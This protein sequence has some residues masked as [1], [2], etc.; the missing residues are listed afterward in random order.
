MR[1]GIEQLE[2]RKLLAGDAYEPNDNYQLATVL[3]S[4]DQTLQQLS[5]DTPTDN[6]WFL[7]TPR[8]SGRAN[9]AISFSHSR[10]NLDL[11]VDDQPSVRGVLASSSSST[12]EE[13]ISVD[14]SADRPI[15]IR[16]Y[17]AGGAVNPQYALSVGLENDPP[18]ISPIDDSVIDVDSTAGPIGFT[19]TDTDTPSFNLVLS[20][21]ASNMRLVPRGSI[22]ISGTDDRRTISITPARGEI[23]SSTI[24]LSAMDRDGARTEVQFQL[25]VNARSD[26]DG[27]GLV[28]DWETEGIDWNN[29]GI[30]D[31]DLPGMGAD[32][33]RKDLFVEVDA[34]AGRGPLPRTNS[35]QDVVAAGLATGTVLDDVVQAFLRAPVRNPD[36]STGI[37]L[38]LQVDELD[39]PIPAFAF[40]EWE[41][42]TA[43]KCGTDL[44]CDPSQEKGQQAD[45]R[46]GRADER[47][48]DNWRNVLSAKRLAFRYALFGDRWGE[49]SASG[50]AELPGNDLLV[51]L[52]GWPNPQT[53]SPHGGTG[54]D[55][56]GTFMHMLGHNL[57]LRNGGGDE[58]NYKP[59]YFSVMNFHWQVPSS[60]LG[61]H[62][63]YSREKLPS[64]DENALN[65]ARGVGFPVGSIHD[66][67]RHRVHAGSVD[68]GRVALVGPVDWDGDGSSNESSVAIDVNFDGK[69]GLLEGH[70][71]W[72]NLKLGFGG[73]SS[74]PDLPIPGGGLPQFP[75]EVFP[76]DNRNKYDIPP[77]AYEVNDSAATASPLRSADFDDELTLH[78][79][80]DVDWLRWVSQ[81]AG[82]VAVELVSAQDQ[83][84]D[85]GLQLFNKTAQELFPLGWSQSLTTHEFR[86]QSEPLSLFIHAPGTGYYQLNIDGP[87]VWH[88]AGDGH[89]W[90]DP[91]NWNVDGAAGMPTPPDHLSFLPHNSNAPVTIDL[92]GT[93]SAASLTFLDDYTLNGNQ[94]LL[95]SG[96]VFVSAGSTV[97]INADMP[98]TFVL[99]K[100]GDGTLIVNGN[101]SANVFVL[102]GTLAMS[103]TANGLHVQ[104]G[105]TLIP[106]TAAGNLAVS[107]PSTID[108]ALAI[109]IG[110]Q[111]TSQLV[112]TANLQLTP[113]SQLEV[114]SAEPL[115]GLG[116]AIRPVAEAGQLTGVFA[117]VPNP[118]HLRRGLFLREV[119]T[120]YAT[121]RVD[122]KFFQA[123][124]GDSNGDGMIDQV[125]LI[126]ALQGNRYLQGPAATWEQGDWDGDNDFDQFDLVEALATGLYLKGTYAT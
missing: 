3:P 56:A 126:L 12:D 4:S 8:R 71:D 1:L 16:V 88:G 54:R 118:G 11:A 10:G 66:V 62:L 87:E 27:D 57:G 36:G 68:T 80:I 124:P 23:G 98:Q 117:Q 77:D 9:I 99:L 28:D 76:L 107:G 59:N 85:L 14:V 119:L 30:V 111:S 73:L 106:R 100:T 96:S 15:Y 40:T 115:S 121:D 39:I 20:A 24:V 34:M 97:T 48:G 108:G 6:D 78:N 94:L 91:S 110:K 81:F 113:Q 116:S 21:E 44:N 83:F 112:S 32:P 70:D 38:H 43:V 60:N 26:S 101:T 104:S 46:F 93:K 63:D 102:D 51:T 2:A 122:L 5:I 53:G 22:T 109:A 55:Q 65:E 84:W 64:L 92:A 95:S 25:H 42:F 114:T 31:L 35:P 37:D 79:F 13:K 45:G 18:F 123:A 33:R 29:D 41:H 120:N 89:L 103:G 52:R 74:F 61:W 69:L 47:D 58:V 17:G 49:D 19:V 7:W 90:S 72:K 67:E 86:V 125:D 75:D 50:M 82:I 105:A